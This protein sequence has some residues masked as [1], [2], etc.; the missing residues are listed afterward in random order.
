[1]LVIDVN[2]LAYAYNPGTPQHLHARGWLEST[3]SS[4]EQVG[5]PIYS[6]AGFVR[7]L[8]N[9]TICANHTLSTADALAAVRGWLVRP[10]VSLLLPGPQHW[11]LFS[12]LAARYSLT[13]PILSDALIVAL[14]LE[15][16]GA[17]C[18]TD[19]DFQRFPEIMSWNPLDDRS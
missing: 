9:K 15:N 8:T 18:S 7:V 17:I 19:R 2:L 11:A 3:F 1:M 4:G 16:S 10:N 5:L 12:E 14:A 13:G 6:V